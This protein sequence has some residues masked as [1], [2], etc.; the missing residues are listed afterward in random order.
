M[1]W[2]DDSP[3][4]FKAS[5]HTIHDFDLRFQMEEQGKIRSDIPFRWSMVT[6]K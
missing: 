1:R 3:V 5:G 6:G 4:A 2:D